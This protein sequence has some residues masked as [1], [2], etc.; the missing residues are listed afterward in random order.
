[1]AYVTA[2]VISFLISVMFISFDLLQQ[3]GVHSIVFQFNFSAVSFLTA[4]AASLV[5]ERD[6]TWA[7][8]TFIAPTSIDGAVSLIGVVLIG[9]FQTLVRFCVYF[10]MRHTTP[11]VVSLMAVLEIPLSYFLAYLSFGQW[12]DVLG[13]VGAGLIF[14]AVVIVNINF[15][16]KCGGIGNDEERRKDVKN[17]VEINAS[18]KESVVEDRPLI[19]R[20]AR[21]NRE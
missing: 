3:R 5:F 12:P 9:V 7:A 18:A 19:I 10:S 2:L 16:G 14:F 1:M 11:E 17:S 21:E 15:D 4:L 20:E 8:L 13:G 6:S